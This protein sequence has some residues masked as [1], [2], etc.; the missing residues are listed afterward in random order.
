MSFDK[1]LQDAKNVMN[2]K[3]WVT[4]SEWYFMILLDKNSYQVYSF[5]KKNDR[6]LDFFE[7]LDAQSSATSYEIWDY[8]TNILFSNLRSLW[9]I[10][11]KNIGVAELH[12]FILSGNEVKTKSIEY[13][14]C[15]DLF[16]IEDLAEEWQKEILEE[17]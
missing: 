8:T 15:S 14:D 5:V 2:E 9:A 1:Y 6:F 4:E 17:N 3:L 10:R 11:K 13:D 12:K 16:V 7:L